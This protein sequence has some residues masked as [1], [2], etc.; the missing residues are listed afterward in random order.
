MA[1]HEQEEPEYETEAWSFAGLTQRLPTQFQLILRPRLIL[2]VIVLLAS[3]V[4]ARKLWDGLH[5]RLAGSPQYQITA[6]KIHLSPDPVPVWIRSDVKSEVLRDSRLIGTATLL[7]D[8][9]ETQQQLVDAFEIHPW[10]RTVRRIEFAGRSRIEIDLEY[11][12]PVAVIEVAGTG[13]LELLP[14]DCDGVRLPDE[15]LTDVEKSY[16]PRIADIEVRPLIGD[17]LTDLRVVGAVKLAAGLRS[18]WEEFQLLD[19]VP[20]EYPEVYRSH[21][22]YSYD[23]RSNGGTLIRWGAAP[24]LG[25]PSEGTFDEKLAR[26][27]RYVRENGALDSIDSHKLIDVR[28]TLQV[29]ELKGTGEAVR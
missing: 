4:A 27:Q 12:E 23:I 14:V 19:L 10:I 9:R 16:L 3:G 22:Y 8:T 25:P 29:A 24:K 7:G 26:L 21:R 5:D 11:R 6:E 15:D 1:K 17:A 2:A 20:S 28:Q 13:Q 18:V